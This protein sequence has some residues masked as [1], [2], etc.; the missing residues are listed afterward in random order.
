MIDVMA[1][2]TMSWALES[3]FEIGLSWAELAIGGPRARHEALPVR[4]KGNAVREAR[5]TLSFDCAPA[6]VVVWLQ[7]IIS[8]FSTASELGG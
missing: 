6:V 5:T 3:S 8:S 7:M 4:E 2:A 1:Y